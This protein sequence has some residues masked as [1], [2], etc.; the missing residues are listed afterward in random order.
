MEDSLPSSLQIASYK[1]LTIGVRLRM[2][3][4][5]GANSKTQVSTTAAKAN[6]DR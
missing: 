2:F 6:G 3:L 1:N 5:E 4:R